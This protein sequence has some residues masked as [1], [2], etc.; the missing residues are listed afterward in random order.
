VALGICSGKV[1]DILTRY[2]GTDIRWDIYHSASISRGRATFIVGGVIQVIVLTIIIFVAFDVGPKFGVQLILPSMGA[3]VCYL[4]VR[5]ARIAQQFYMGRKIQ[6]ALDDVR[7]P[8]LYLRSFFVDNEN[9]LVEA[10]QDDPERGPFLHRWMQW[11]IEAEF[12]RRFAAYG[13]VFALGR[14]RDLLP[15]AGAVR[16]YISE[17]AWHRVVQDLM[18]AASVIAIRLDRSDNL[19]WEIE[20]LVE[21][22]YLKKVIFLTMDSYGR[23][24][25]A[26]LFKRLRSWL[27]SGLSCIIPDV[28][29]NIWGIY[30]DNWKFPCTI[31]ANSPMKSDYCRAIND[32]IRSFAQLGRL[33]RV[34]NFRVDIVDLE[35]MFFRWGFP[36]IS[37]VLVFLYIVH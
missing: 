5:T 17:L 22:D 25:D 24:L 19:R 28:V 31:D 10:D 6:L 36:S 14:P 20:R 15:K 33:P 13:P 1:R 26:S 12:C 23:P 11:T 21:R 2:P 9:L 34:P 35:V 3:L 4:N 29:Q 32:T 30:F 18:E 27:P 16:L 7:S 37:A 8:I